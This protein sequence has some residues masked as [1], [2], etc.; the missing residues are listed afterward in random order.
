MA[1]ATD[2]NATKGGDSAYYLWIGKGFSELAAFRLRATSMDSGEVGMRGELGMPL[3]FLHG[4]QEGIAIAA[5]ERD[6]D[7]GFG[8]FIGKGKSREKRFALGEM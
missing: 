3:S 6:A 8:S 2:Q 1:S 7:H 5:L 4:L